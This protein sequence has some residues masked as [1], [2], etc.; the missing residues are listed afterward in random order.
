MSEMNTDDLASD[1]IGYP[2]GLSEFMKTFGAQQ[3]NKDPDKPLLTYTKEDP[4]AFLKR[5][6]RV[7][8]KPNPH[9]IEEQIRECENRDILNLYEDRRMRERGETP[10]VDKKAVE[11]Y[12]KSEVIDLY[13]KRRLE[14]KLKRR[15]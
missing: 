13:T 15:L 9:A 5:I 3:E 6:K 4:W 7:T 8:V 14:E 1:A 2:I 12:H 10:E 11:A